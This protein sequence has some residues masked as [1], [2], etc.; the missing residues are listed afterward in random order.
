M[1]L[2]G[3]CDDPA[4]PGA[5]DFSGEPAG[6]RTELQGLVALEADRYADVA[7]VHAPAAN[8]SVASELIAHCEK[9]RYR[10]A[11][12]DSDSG[13]ADVRSLD[14]R[15][16]IRD[17]P[18][19]AFYAPWIDV[20]DPQSGAR[21][22]V[23][24]GGHVLGLYARTDATR[25]VFKAPAGD[26]LRGVAGLQVDLTARE[27]ALLNLR[28]VNVIRRLREAIAVMGAR[29]LS[30]DP[31]W[32]YVGVRRLLIFLER[33]IDLGTQW[34][35]FEPN[36]APLWTQVRDSIR[37]FLQSVWLDGALLGSTPEEAFVVRCD[38]TT[39]T[40]DDIAAGRLV[41]EI[42]VAPLKPAE[43]IAFRLVR[44]AGQARE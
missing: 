22:L 2:A 43:F 19:A 16:T 25:G 40:P 32:T 10:F 18:R 5:G 27:H 36:A 11:V 20:A 1:A 37:G 44:L 30:S 21:R 41:C 26:T 8:A 23:P 15:A 35:V 14:P 29:T 39:M 38:E 9:M 28:G 31:R 12:L 6:L 33:S 17:T 24:P 42:G 34:V 4:A 13:T 3:G 7:L